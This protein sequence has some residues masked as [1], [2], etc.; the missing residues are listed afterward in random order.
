MNL[1]LKSIGN[2]SKKVVS[3]KM[4]EFKFS[5]EDL[6]DNFYLTGNKMCVSSN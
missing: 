6:C 2:M 4:G 3:Y 1:H 5:P